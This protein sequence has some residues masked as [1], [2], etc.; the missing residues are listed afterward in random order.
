MEEPVHIFVL[1]Q[2]DHAPLSLQNMFLL[3]VEKS[4]LHSIV[5]SESI[6]LPIVVA[7][8]DPSLLKTDKNRNV[9]LGGITGFH[10]N[11]KVQ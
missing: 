9:I 4:L 7:Q 5:P 8:D 11:Q 2:H 6:N 10:P 1:K 3:L